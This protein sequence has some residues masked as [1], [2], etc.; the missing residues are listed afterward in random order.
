MI[1]AL[2]DRREPGRR[3]RRPR[4]GAAS[5]PRSWRADERRAGARGAADGDARRR[6]L[7]VEVAGGLP[8]VDGRLARRSSRGEILGVVGES[9][10]GKTT[11]GAARCSASRGPGTRIAAAACAWPARRSLGRSE[12]EL[13]APARAGSS[14]TCRR[15]RRPRS[16]RRCA[17]AT[18]DRRDAARAPAGRRRRRARCRDCS[19]ACRCPATRDFQRRFPHQLSGGQQQRLAIAIALVGDPRAGRAGRADDR[20]RRGHPGAHPRRARPPAAASSTSRWSTS[21]TTSPSSA[22]IADR[23]AVMYAG[24][25]VEE[26]PVAGGL[27]DA[28]PPVH[29]RARRLDPRPPP[30]RA[31]CAGYRASRSGSATGRPAARSRRA[32]R[33]RVPRCEEALPPLEAVGRASSCAAP[34]GGGRR[35]SRRTTCVS[36]GDAAAAAAAPLLAVDGLTSLYRTRLGTV[37]AARRRLVRARR[38]RVPSR[39]SASP[40]A[41]RRRRAL[42]RRAASR[43][44]PARIVLDGQALAGRAKSRSVDQ[45]RRVQIVFQ[46]PYDSLNPRRRVR[47]AIARP[48]ARPARPRRARPPRP[49]STAAR[50]RAPAG[51]DRRALSRCELSGGERQRVAIARALAAA[52]ELLV[53]DEITSALDV[54]VQASRARPARRAARASSASRCS[55]SRTT[56]ASSRASCDRVLVLR[57]GDRARGGRRRAAPGRADRRVHAAPD[58]L[59]AAGRRRAEPVA[60]IR[61]SSRPEA[62]LWRRLDRGL[63]RGRAVRAPHPLLD[64]QLGRLELRRRAR[65]HGRGPRGRGLLLHRRDPDRRHGHRARGAAARRRGRRRPARRRRA[66]RERRGP[67]ARRRRAPRGVARRG[68]PVGPRRAGGRAPAVAP[69]LQRAGPPRGA[70]HARGAPPRGGHDRSLRASVSPPSRRAGCRRSRSSTTATSRR[71]RRGSPRS[72]P[73]RPPTCG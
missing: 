2:H 43:R 19:S 41:A 29:A 1:A 31:G 14:P 32:A 56:S 46:N 22:Q 66:L 8:I 48:A 37:V 70:G 55:S 15:I 34:S 40:A 7:R 28:A 47:D 4:L 6:G 23:V 61:S 13:R 20:A 5:T 11:T 64:Q 50:A 30:S 3:R 65:P 33:I 10:S 59:G 49:R 12:R 44:R 25:I 39:S 38:R 35:R 51:A 71:R 58:R 24:R 69:P 54:S 53:C 63:A 52:P 67:A 18:H 62:R 57:D 42:R 9:G 72:A 21:R 16:T 60:R 17:S 68:L 27:R 26:G 73:R 45:R 36:P